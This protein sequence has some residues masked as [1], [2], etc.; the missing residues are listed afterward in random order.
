MDEQLA[1]LAGGCFWCVQEAYDGLK[2]IK[3]VLCGYTGG[4]KENPTYE[5]VCSG[6]TGHV[7]AVQIKFD[8]DEISYSDILDIYW[9][10]IDPRDS[11][12]QF[13]DKGPQ[14]KPVIFYHTEE[15]KRLA[16]ESKKDVEKI[17]GTVNVEIK[18]AQK[19]YIAEEYHQ[20]YYRKNPIRYCTYKFFSGREPFI[21]KMW[22][23]KFIKRKR[24]LKGIMS[25]DELK[26]KLSPIQYK[27]VR[28]NYTE[29][30]FLNEYWNNKMEGIYVDIVSGEPLF[31]SKDQFDSGCGWPSF[32]KPLE[33]NN[34]V[35]KVDTSHNMTRIEVRSRKG[36]SHLGHVFDDGPA[37]T[38]LRYCINS[39]ALRF[40]PKEKLDEEGYGE[41]KKIFGD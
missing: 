14:Y 21:E 27:V 9:M 31:C 22:G 23:E 16:E 24:E 30:P 1:T 28:E 40:I 5:E 25:D 26:R 17:F 11:D 3:E 37:P 29:Q 8:P 39:A 19:F 2:G 18:P 38:Y 41:Y 36:D 7:E 20:Q 4:Y 6:K 10:I 34:I 13:A 33:P 35:Y 32:T 15:Q 12:G